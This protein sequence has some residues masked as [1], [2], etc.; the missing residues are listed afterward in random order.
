MKKII[1]LLCLALQL[2]IM[3]SGQATQLITTSYGNSLDTFSNSAT[4]KTTYVRYVSEK[5]T[6]FSIALPLTKI[7]GTV[8]GSVKWQGSNDSVNFYT[9]RTDTLT[10]AS[11]VYGYSE[12]EPAWRYYRPFMT[13]SGTMSASFGPVWSWTAT[14]PK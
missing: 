8:A 2:S 3:S 6:T 13:A 12:V 1:F 9:L 14:K 10:N 5:A 4:T 7:S 11:N